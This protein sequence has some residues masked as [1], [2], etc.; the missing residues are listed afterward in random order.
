MKKRYLAWLST[1]RHLNF[2]KNEHNPRKLPRCQEKM[3]QVEISETSRILVFRQLDSRRVPASLPPTCLG[4]RRGEA[5]TIDW[6]GPAVIL[7]GC[8]AG[9]VRLWGGREPRILHP[10]SINHVGSMDDNLD[11]NDPFQES[12]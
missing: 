10:S 9:A 11:G 6:L 8:R 3:A 4:T 2:T 5:V 7:K 12:V 1:A